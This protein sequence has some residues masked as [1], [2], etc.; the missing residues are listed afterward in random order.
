[1]CNVYVEILHLEFKPEYTDFFVLNFAIL[2]S[3][4]VPASF[5]D[6]LH[7]NKRKWPKVVADL[8]M[9]FFLNFS[10]LPTREHLDS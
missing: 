5:L 9:Y 8:I 6:M 1:M 10:F 2:I 7:T 4:T 3:I